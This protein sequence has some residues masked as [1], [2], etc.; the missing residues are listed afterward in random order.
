MRMASPTGRDDHERRDERNDVW[1][2]DLLWVLVVL[3]LIRQVTAGRLVPA[4]TSAILA[5]VVMLED[6]FPPEAGSARR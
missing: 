6:S 2:M 5:C 4:L 3:V 1:G